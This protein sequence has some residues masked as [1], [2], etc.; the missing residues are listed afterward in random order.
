MVLAADDDSAEPRTPAP[1]D[2]EAEPALEAPSLEATSLENPRPQIANICIEARERLVS[3][4][5]LYYLQRTRRPYASNEEVLASVEAITLLA[6][7]EDPAL[8]AAGAS[9]AG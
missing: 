1:G 3:G 7:R 6:G 8:T 4:L 2:S 5:T 9:C